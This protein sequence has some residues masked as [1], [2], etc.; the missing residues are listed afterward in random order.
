M[1]TA[2]T[3]TVNPWIEDVLLNIFKYLDAQDLFNCEAVCNNWRTVIGSGTWRKLLK[4]QVLD[5]NRIYVHKFKIIIIKIGSNRTWLQ[6]W[7]KLALDE[8]KLQLV[9]YRNICRAIDHYVQVIHFY[10]CDA[11]Y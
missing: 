8:T 7:L 2:Q 9:D 4:R 6:L 1:C 3:D 10:Y 11:I 5:L